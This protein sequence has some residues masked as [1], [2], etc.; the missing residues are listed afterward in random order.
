MVGVDQENG[1]EVRAMKDHPHN[2]GDICALG[3]NL[4]FIFEAEGRLT[5][6]M[7]RRDGEL[8]VVDWDEA[9]S[10]VALKLNRIISESGPDAVAFWC[11]GVF[12]P[13]A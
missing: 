7:I 12:R 4:P 1:I 6:P 13:P 3:A 2:K 11:A 8:A 10:H 9:V 5:S